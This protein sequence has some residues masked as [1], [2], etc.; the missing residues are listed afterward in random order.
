MM[1]FQF[2]VIDQLAKKH[3]GTDIGYDSTT[4]KDSK[5]LYL[6]KE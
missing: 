1:F 6:E 5:N 4:D 2:Q 3:F